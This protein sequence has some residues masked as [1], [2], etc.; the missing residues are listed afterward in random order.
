[1][2]NQLFER[3]KEIVK[4]Y[5]EEK[6][7]IF[8]AWVH[9]VSGL[10]FIEELKES[11]IVIPDAGVLAWLFH[12]SVYDPLSQTNEEDSVTLLKNIANDFFSEDVIEDAA[13]IIIDTKKHMINNSK[14]LSYSGYILDIDMSSLGLPLE[15]FLN[16]R[17]LAMNE[18]QPF[19]S[20]DQIEKG[21]NHF[22]D[23]TLKNN[24]FKTDYFYLK[25]EDQAK[26]NLSIFKDILNEPY[27]KESLLDELKVIKDHLNNLLKG[28]IE[29]I[30][31]GNYVPF[32]NETI[33]KNCFVIELKR[34]FS[35]PSINIQTEYPFEN[36]YSLKIIFSAND[37]NLKFY[38]SDNLELETDSYNAGSYFKEIKKLNT[39]KSFLH[40]EINVFYLLS[41]AMSISPKNNKEVIID[42]TSSFPNFL[43]KELS[44]E[45]KD[46]LSLKYDIKF[47]YFD[48]LS[49]SSK[50]YNNIVR[51][52]N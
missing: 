33:H 27:D 19:Y 49:H 30:K 36:M 21:T 11:N 37:N 10:N 50:K 18:Y 38:F 29:R 26:K 1:M 23:Q 35:N 41:Q 15:L 16:N 39:V 9:I 48:L 22:I 31:L 8:H 34:S 25:Y 5:Y 14:H 2:N 46:V 4:P 3:L 45:E 28:E 20:Q 17:Q 12:D 7:R 24:I 52:P 13:S 51:S 47:N 40:E 42:L 32:M 6:H 43:K 44:N